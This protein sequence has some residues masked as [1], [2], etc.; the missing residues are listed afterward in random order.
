MSVQTPDDHNLAS[1]PSFMTDRHSQKV[2]D[3]HSSGARTLQI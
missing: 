2:G 1:V 3:I